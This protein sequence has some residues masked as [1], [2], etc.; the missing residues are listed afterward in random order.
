MCALISKTYTFS[1]GSTIVAAEHNTNNDTIYNEFNGNI[2]NAN[3]KSGAAIADTKLASISTAGKVSGAALTSLSST[4]SAAGRLPEANSP[5]SYSGAL[6]FNLNPYLPTTPTTDLEAASKAYV[7]S[8]GAF[9][10][11]VD[12]TGSYAAQQSDTDNIIVAYGTATG[13]TGDL[14]IYTDSANPPITLR[15]FARITQN[16]YATVTVPVKKSHYWKVETSNLT[17][18]KVFLL[19][20]GE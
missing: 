8:V 17:I 19:P 1:A 5:S 4:P 15:G 3:I 9:G 12:H 13:A 11:W 2:D 16:N 14:S 20:K 10:D 18:T 6:T 7:D